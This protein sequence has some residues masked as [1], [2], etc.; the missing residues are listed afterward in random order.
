[1]GQETENLV[2]KERAVST[3]LLLSS[4]TDERGKPRPDEG[5]VPQITV[6]AGNWFSRYRAETHEHRNATLGFLEMLESKEDS[7]RLLR[8]MA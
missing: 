2:R 1:L 8:T 4:A 6:H 3:I 7:R 5:H